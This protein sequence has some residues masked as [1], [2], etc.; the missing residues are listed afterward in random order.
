MVQSFTPALKK[1]LRK[2]GCYLHKQA[3]G[4][5]EKW[6][7]PISGAYFIVDGKIK[8]RHTANKTL[9][10]AGLAKKF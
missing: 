10:D 2:A 6:Y 5:H 8:S 1:I 7:S 4:D 9:K 3:K